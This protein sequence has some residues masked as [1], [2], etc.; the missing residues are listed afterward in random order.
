MFQ[1][2]HDLKRRDA[3][4]VRQL[5][6]ER[7]AAQAARAQAEAANLAKSRFFSAAS[8]DLR[9]PLHA[10]ALFTRSLLHHPL[11]PPAMRLVTSIDEA[12]YAMERLFDQIL[13]LDRID[14]GGLTVRTQRVLL[15]DIYRRVRVHVEAVAFDK[16]LALTFRGGQHEV[17]ADPLLLERV[18]RNLVANAIR[19]TE[20][21]GVL[22]ACRSRGAQLALQV[23]DTGIG[24]AP[25]ALPRVFDEF[26]QL[27]AA[28]RP[29]TGE[30]RGLGLG[31][32]I[33]RRL[34]GLMQVPLV[35]RTQ[36]GRGSVFHAV[37]APRGRSSACA[38]R[39]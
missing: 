7:N 39:R 6:A 32:A 18:L 12:L 38:C 19:Y 4:L 2:L 20:D 26:Y 37:A 30:Y 5:E 23:W 27:D 22:V 9:Q 33:V 16:G 15:D 14:S 28:Q 36:A 29:E 21:G 10:M 8:H 3:L 34:V 13:D 31:L 17:Q 24:I 25:A 35:V 1:R 11:D